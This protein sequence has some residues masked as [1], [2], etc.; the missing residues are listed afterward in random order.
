MGAKYDPFFQMKWLI[1]KV[2]KFLIPNNNIV[3]KLRKFAF[4]ASTAK[5]NFFIILGKKI[6]LSRE[7]RANCLLSIG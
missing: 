7:Y 6:V 1:M 5:N 4:I 3:A 2:N